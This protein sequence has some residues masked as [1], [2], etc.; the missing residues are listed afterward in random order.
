MNEYLDASGAMA[1]LGGQRP[2]SRSTLSRFMASGKL[3]FYRIGRS[4]RF[5]RADLDEFLS[6]CA[7]GGEVGR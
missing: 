4:V 2:L 3:R 7:C 6:K 1:Y 5:R